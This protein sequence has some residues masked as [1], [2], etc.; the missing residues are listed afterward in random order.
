M[1]HVVVVSD[2]SNAEMI[3]NDVKPKR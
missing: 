1:L 3:H 2:T